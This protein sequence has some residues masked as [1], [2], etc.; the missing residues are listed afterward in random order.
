M[1][2]L[3]ETSYM[4]DGS[5]ITGLPPTMTTQNQQINGMILD[6]LFLETYCQDMRNTAVLSYRGYIAV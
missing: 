4:M 2:M 6:Y 3:K 5:G 1:R